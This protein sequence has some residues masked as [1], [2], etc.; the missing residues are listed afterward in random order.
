VLVGAAISESCEVERLRM[1][2]DHGCIID[3]A[4]DVERIFDVAIAHGTISAIGD[5]LD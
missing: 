1:I 2:S 5:N 3:P 4:A